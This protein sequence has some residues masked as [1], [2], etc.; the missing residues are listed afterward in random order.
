MS[1][2]IDNI[3]TCVGCEEEFTPRQDKGVLEHFQY[4]CFKC[5]ISDVKEATYGES[6]ATS[7]REGSCSRKQ[8]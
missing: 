7:Q 2:A 5:W 3:W 4:A 6:N 1:I 8:S